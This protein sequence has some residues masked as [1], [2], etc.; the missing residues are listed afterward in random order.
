MSSKV[1]IIDTRITDHWGVEWTPMEIVRDFLQNFYDANPIKDIKI[2]IEKRTVIVSAP[3]EF[4]YKSLIYLGSDKGSSDIGQYGEGFKASTVNAMRNHGCTVQAHIKDCFLEFFFEREKIGE[5][6]KKVIK[7]KISKVPEIEG[8]KLILKNCS[9]VIVEEFQFGLN[10]FY[11]ESNPLFGSLLTRHYS[12]DIIVY[13]SI[14]ENVGY[15]F[16][17]KL[18]RAKLDVPLVIVCNRKYKSIDEKIQHDRDRKAFNENVLELLLKYTLKQVGISEIVHI[19][20]PWW[21]SGHKILRILSSGWRRKSVKFPENYY[22]KHSKTETRN[23][24]MQIEVNQLEQEFQD[25]GNIQCPVYM[26]KLGMKSAVSIIQNRVVQMK[27]KHKTL[28]TRKPSEL[29]VQALNFLKDFIRNV[30]PLLVTRF[31]YANYTIGD[32]DEIVGELRIERSYKSNDVF[33]SRYFFL[34]SFA[35]ALAILVHEW[36]HI[37]G[38]D[39]SRSFTDALTGFIVGLIEKRA[40]LDYVEERWRN[41]SLEIRTKQFNEKTIPQMHIIIDK[42]TNKQKNQLLKSI[43]D[44]EL[45][46]LIEKEK[47]N[48]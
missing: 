11:Y 38:Y 44:D 29:E 26:A 32:S 41:I 18:L 33:L 43:P 35:E 16:Y 34:L 39:G 15:V 23:P 5:T 1:E 31:A 8:S 42:L 25:K 30:N 2:E 45:M 48:I 17:K 6:E 14:E 9:K 3:N 37:Y 47:I 28:Y 4:D 7:C 36:S 10:Y 22:A 19:L 46:K 20:K 21:Q 13:K 12:N 40:E 27:K 24:G